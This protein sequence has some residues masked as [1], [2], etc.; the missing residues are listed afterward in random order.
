MV[1]NASEFALWGARVGIIGYEITKNP[2]MERKR[3]E[4]FVK[5][6]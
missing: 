4:F 2:P 3:I 5:L 6:Y 1:C